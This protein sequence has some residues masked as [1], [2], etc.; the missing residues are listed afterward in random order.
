MKEDMKKVLI[1][2]GHVDTVS[3]SVVNR[4]VLDVVAEKL[5][6]ILQTV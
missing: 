3:D 5:L 1:V 6:A 2:S 4:M